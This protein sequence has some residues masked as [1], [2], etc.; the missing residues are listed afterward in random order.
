MDFLLIWLLGLLSIFS[1]FGPAEY[2]ESSPPQPSVSAEPTAAA[3]P[4]IDPIAEQFFQRAPLP[5]CGEYQVEHGYYEQSA[6]PGW[7]CLQDAAQAQGAEATFIAQ[8]SG[9][10][11]TYS[12]VR[13][14]DGV[15]EI[16][17]NDPSKG[18]M[19]LWTYDSCSVAASSYRQGCP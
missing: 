4:V 19:G 1:A 5:S 10:A 3:S 14:A 16:Y 13:V 9:Q 12:F 17:V 11:P 7:Q 18:D 2:E 15:M 6:Q 8:L